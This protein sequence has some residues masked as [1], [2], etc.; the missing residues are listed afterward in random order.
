MV[1]GVLVILLADVSDRPAFV[2]DVLQ[3]GLTILS[4]VFH[5]GCLH[6]PVTDFERE[7]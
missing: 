7:A 4:S 2:I 1:K 5:V 3:T 6:S